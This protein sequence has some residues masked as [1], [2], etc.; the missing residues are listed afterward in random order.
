MIY[1][2]LSDVA[3]Y[4]GVGKSTEVATVHLQVKKTVQHLNI[5]LILSIE[6]VKCLNG[7]YKTPS[8]TG[9]AI[10][11]ILMKIWNLLVNVNKQI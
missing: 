4:L 6:M 3:T 1:L 11:H 8:F 9:N 10:V 5:N 7:Q 2:N